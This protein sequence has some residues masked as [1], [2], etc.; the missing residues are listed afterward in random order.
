[1]LFDALKRPLF[2]RFS[3]PAAMA[4]EAPLIGKRREMMPFL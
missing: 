2:I 1:M 3:A 4:E